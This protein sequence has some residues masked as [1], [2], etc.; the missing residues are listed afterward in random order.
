MNIDDL[1][2]PTLYNK[3]NHLWSECTDVGLK[4]Q[5]AMAMALSNY[6]GVY[7][8]SKAS[9]HVSSAPLA[10]NIPTTYLQHA[11]TSTQNN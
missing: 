10:N 2:L 1:Y 8:L 6:T 11:H 5:R 7:I 3:V 9:L 4:Q